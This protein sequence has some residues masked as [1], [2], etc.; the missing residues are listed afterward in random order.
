MSPWPSVKSFWIHLSFGMLT[1]P[2]NLQ[3]KT[4]PLNHT[5][6]ISDLHLELDRPDITAAFLAF[7]THIAPHADALYILGDLFESW[8]GDDAAC[9]FSRSITQALQ[10]LHIPVY[11][12]RGNRDFLLGE[13]FAAAAGCQLLPDPSRIQLYGQDVVLTHGDALCTEDRKHQW[14]RRYAHNP[15]YYRWFLLLP[16]ALRRWLAQR[17]RNASRKHTATI[18]SAHMDVTA[19]AVTELLHTQ[20]VTQLI[21]GHTH[22]PAIHRHPDHTRIVLGDWHQHGNALVYYADGH[23]EL[24]NYPDIS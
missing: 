2:L 20:H 12:M 6:F 3:N 24:L 22:Q 10:Q 15:R 17:I 11:V 23:Y 19:T 4:Q 1:S 21:H 9:D 16:V 14:F 13:T 18:T 7:L 5:L 8:V